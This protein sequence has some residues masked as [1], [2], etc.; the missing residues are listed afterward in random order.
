MQEHRDQHR[1]DDDLALAVRIAVDF[2]DAT[3]APVPVAI[4]E[5][6]VVLG[7]RQ[8]AELDELAGDRRIVD[9]EASS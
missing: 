4:A 3:R 6:R 1:K 5:R 9:D 7:L 8:R 2:A